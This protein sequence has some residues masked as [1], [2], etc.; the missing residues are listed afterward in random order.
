MIA[1]A[2][3][4]RFKTI[5]VFCVVYFVGL[6][7]ITLTSIPG[8][9]ARGGGL[10]GWI[11]GALIVACG[12]G[13][14]KSNVSPLVADQY[15]RTKPHIKVLKTGER[16]IVDPNVTITRIYNIFYWCINVGSLSSIA[17]SE[18]ERRVGF[19]AAFLI[20]S[21][22]FVLTP[23]VLVLSWSLYYKVAPKGSIL[24]EV[25]RCT[26]VATGA[27]GFWKNPFRKIDGGMWKYAKPS[28]YLT[29]SEKGRELTTAE[30]RNANRITWD[31]QF[32]DELKRTMRACQ[33]FL[34]YPVRFG[35]G[36]LNKETEGL[37][38]CIGFRIIKS[39]PTWFPWL[40]R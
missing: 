34:F 7:I 8:S 38:S 11:V 9:L 16:V 17:T 5:C 1:D 15:R 13:G 6:L 24:T 25:W 27:S 28:Y 12:T 21:A 36:F 10:P 33:I 19:W 31:D 40:V 23:I 35:F 32:V 30:K 39:P 3:W 22:V 4:G 2:R 14:I 29:S 18:T 20:P 26:K 37:P